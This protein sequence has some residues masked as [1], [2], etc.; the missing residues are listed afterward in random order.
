[1][2][3]GVRRGLQNADLN[4]PVDP[5]R[6][7][8]TGIGR[9]ALLDAA[10]EVELAK[11]IEA[12]LYAAELLRRATGAEVEVAAA[13]CRDLRWIVRDGERA[14]DHL[15]EANLR[16]VVSLA[17]RYTGRG[18]AFLDLI[19]EG[20][21]G[22]IRAVQ[23]FDYTRGYKFSTYATWWIRQDIIRGSADQ[24]RA[25][26]IPVHMMPLAARRVAG[27]T[28][29]TARRG[30]QHRAAR[31]GAQDPRHYESR[32]V[33]R[34]Q[35]AGERRCGGRSSSGVARDAGRGLSVLAIAE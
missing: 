2:R 26:R 4:V 23:K 21:L 17:R 25:I 8:L 12:G 24:A 5:V 7:Y 6:V 31:R 10:Q 3:S 19:Q 20:N 11:R 13:L 16:L 18:L 27:S 15:L 33:D 32:K 30:Q 22:L 35:P 28:N 9:V 1:V 34:E 29:R 14:K